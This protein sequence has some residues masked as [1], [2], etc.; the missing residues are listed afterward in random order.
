MKHIII[1]GQ[2]EHKFILQIEHK[3]NAIY[4]WT[5]TIENPL[6]YPDKL[7]AKIRLK[8]ITKPT[9]PYVIEAEWVEISPEKQ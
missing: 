3:D 8:L 6:I 4:I 9:E 7:K 2:T 5:N 1:S